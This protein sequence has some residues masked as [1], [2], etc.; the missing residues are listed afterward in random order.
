MAFSW[1]K[2][3]FSSEKLKKKLFFSEKMKIRKNGKCHPDRA[4]WRQVSGIKFQE[5][6]RPCLFSVKNI[7]I[8]LKKK[9]FV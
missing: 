8:N 7:K 6:R 3:F 1:K 5:S 2:F 4:E 9:P